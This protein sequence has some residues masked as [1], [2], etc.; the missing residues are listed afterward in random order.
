[1]NKFLGTL[2][3]VG[4][5]ALPLPGVAAPPAD[6]AEALTQRLLKAF[7]SGD[8][9]AAQ[10]LFC[11]AGA[12]TRIRDMYMRSAASNA[13]LKIRDATIERSVTLRSGDHFPVPPEGLFRLNFDDVDK[14]G[15]HNYKSAVVYYFGKVDGRYCFLVP[16]P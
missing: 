10:E 14:L 12:T 15:Q 11:L 3:A 4:I 1:M 5:A 6:S 8:G 7:E 2:L 16:V 13:K 9:D